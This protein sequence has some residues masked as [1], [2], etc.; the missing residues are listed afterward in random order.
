MRLWL[1]T[2]EM[3]KKEEEGQGRRK[4]KRRNVPGV[5]MAEG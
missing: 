5:K 4:K 3:G 2:V 1:K